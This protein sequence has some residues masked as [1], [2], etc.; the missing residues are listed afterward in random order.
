MYSR[1]AQGALAL[2][3]NRDRDTSDYEKSAHECTHTPVINATSSH[4]LAPERSMHDIKG[5][6]KN[7]QRLAAGRNQNLAKKAT[8]DRFGLLHVTKEGASAKQ[9]DEGK[10]YL[11]SAGNTS[12]F[13]SSFG[14][15]KPINR[16]PYVSKGVKR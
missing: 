8:S 10:T 7:V 1:V 4:N 5:Y 11:S 3:S 6:D 13:K 14:D 16:K 15:V 2:K 9:V 12:K